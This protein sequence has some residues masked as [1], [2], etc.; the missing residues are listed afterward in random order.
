MSKSK[1][2]KHLSGTQ[3]SLKPLK[4]I[5]KDIEGNEL[6]S[7][8]GYRFM[9]PLDSSA[10]TADLRNAMIP[11]LR[12]LYKQMRESDGLEFVTVIRDYKFILDEAFAALEPYKAQT[13]SM[14]LGRFE[15]ISIDFADVYDENGINIKEAEASSKNAFWPQYKELFIGYLLV[16]MALER[17]NI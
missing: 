11:I 10:F 12:I 13:L 6:F 14:T 15:Q 16:K 4:S 17:Y 3:A 9:N 5:E 2:S 8:D 1:T 7:I